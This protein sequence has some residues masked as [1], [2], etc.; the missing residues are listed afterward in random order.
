MN[1]E[2]RTQRGERVPVNDLGDGCDD[3]EARVACLGNDSEDS[4]VMAS[5]GLE[6]W[7]YSVLDYTTPSEGQTKL[8]WIGNWGMDAETV[9]EEIV[10][11]ETN[12]FG[13]VGL[14]ACSEPPRRPA[15]TAGQTRSSNVLNFVTDQQGF[16][17]CRKS[18]EEAEDEEFTIEES[19]S[20]NMRPAT[21]TG[22]PKRQAQTAGPAGPSNVLRFASDH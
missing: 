15:Q 9:E 3:K 1:G 12:I 7:D 8:D 6:E 17:S 11:M 20:A 22:P 19:I 2:G 13:N 5:K 18:M 14:A 16:C 4:F 21:Y 10:C